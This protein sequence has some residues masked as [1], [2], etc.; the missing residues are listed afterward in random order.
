MAAATPPGASDMEAQVRQYE[1]FMAV[2]Q[3]HMD[4]IVKIMALYLTLV[5]TCVG[6]G[7]SHTM[8]PE[9]RIA[10][11]LFAAGLSLVALLGFW[12][13]RI[14]GFSLRSEVQLL[15]QQAEFLGKFPFTGP[16]A[17]LSVFIGASVVVLVLSLLLLVVA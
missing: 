1:V 7:F 10:L 3:H 17:M 16:L 13:A 2:Y 14:W 8:T 15:E 11:L 12:Q 9:G 6:V 5:G 4:L